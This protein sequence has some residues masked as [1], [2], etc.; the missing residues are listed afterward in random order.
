[1][2][3]KR[4]PLVLATMGG[5]GYLPG[6]PG[7]WGSLAALPLWWLLAHLDP[8]G[9]GLAV[10]GMVAASV[11]AAGAA[12]QYLGEVDHPAIVLDEAMGLLVALAFIPL[13]WQWVVFGFAFFRALDIL[14]PYPIRYVER[15][16]GGL[17]VVLDDVAAGI[18]G[19]LLLEFS[20]W[21]GLV[22]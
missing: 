9:Y 22:K 5:V 7:T 16:P 1:M 21:A 15:L 19:R 3:L 17:G 12:E 10:L 4:L 13:K 6:M 2:P 11:W 20:W 18:M 8:W 14:K